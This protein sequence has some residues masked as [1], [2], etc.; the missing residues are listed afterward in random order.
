MKKDALKKALGYHV[1]LRPFPLTGAVERVEEDWIVKDAD[2]RKVVLELPS[3]QREL[4]LGVD[5]VRSF[6]ENRARDGDTYRAGI[7]HLL[8]Q[9]IVMPAEVFREPLPAAA[10]SLEDVIRP[11]VMRPLTLPD[12]RRKR[13][14]A[15]F[16][17]HPVYLVTHEDDPHELGAV[18]E[19]LFAE[20]RMLGLE[21]AWNL[22]ADVR[23]E[24]VYELSPD[25]RARWR[26]RPKGTASE[27]LVVRPGPTRR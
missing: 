17:R 3:S 20:L 16:D 25:Y 12:G 24:V 26:L 6:F 27:V 1:A 22:A 10:V 11:R 8:V 15:W 19:S 13:Y 18:Q 9:V 5:Q 23:G 14:F 2:E 21:P 7:L 4:V